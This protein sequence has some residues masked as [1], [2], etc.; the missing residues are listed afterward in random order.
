MQR[1][2]QCEQAAREASEDVAKMRDRLDRYRFAMAR[3]IEALAHERDQLKA[4]NDR[5]ATDRERLIAQR[6]TYRDLAKDLYDHDPC[7]FDHHGG[8]QAHGWLEPGPGETCPHG[9]AQRLFE[10]GDDGE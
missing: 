6:D 3:E 8:C 9:R 7:S 4:V 1:D 5:M 2:E 10:G